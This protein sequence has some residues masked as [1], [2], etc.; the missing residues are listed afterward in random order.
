MPSSQPSPTSKNIYNVT[1][2]GLWPSS[3]WLHL[4]K[5]PAEA[6]NITK[7][8]DEHIYTHSLSFQRHL[9]THI[10]VKPCTCTEGR[11]WK[12]ITVIHSGQNCVREGW[13][14]SSCLT[15]THRDPE[16]DLCMCA[17]CM[18]M[19]SC[20]ILRLD[21]FIDHSPLYGSFQQTC[22]LTLTPRS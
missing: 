16:R 5:L 22:M 10:S 4:L 7:H 15:N 3:A 20:R 12:E 14:L 13:G 17:A 11:C 9:S 19:S 2:T 21:F 18:M 8:I 1:L 6:L